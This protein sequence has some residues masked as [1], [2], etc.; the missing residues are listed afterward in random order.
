MTAQT[1]THGF[2]LIREQKLSEINS[3]ARYYRHVST[4]AELLSLLNSDEN[5]VF[6]V[7]FG[8]PP[9]DSTG[10]AHIL[11]HSVLCGSRKYPIK[12]PFVELM[13]SS[14]NTFLNAMTFPDKTCYPVASQNVQDF[15][16]LIDVYLDAVFHPRLT[17]HIFEQEGW[18]YELDT[19]EAPLTY[20]GVVFNEM[21]GNYSSPDS[22]LHELAQ[23]SLYPD[24]TYGLDSGGDPKHIP[25]LTYQQLKDF[26]QRHYHP[27]NAKL[28]FYGD[29]DPDERLRLLDGWLGEF[30]RIEVD[31]KVPLQPRF[32]AP[33][34]LQRTYAAGKA[35]EAPQEAPK[36]SMIS[37]NWMLDEIVDVET[38]LAFDILEHI[39][40]GTPAAPLY[41]ALIDSGL[42]EGLAGGG[43]DDGLRQPMFSIGLKGIDPANADKIE[44]LIIDTIGT[45]AEEGIDPL[46]VEAALNTVEFHL[47][48]NNTGSFPRGIVFMLRALRTWLH[49]RD[50]LSPLAFSGPLA[51]IKGRVAGGRYFEGLLRRHFIDNPHRTSL[52]LRPDSEQ[53]EREAAAERSR[54]DA[55]RSG[56]SANDLRAVVD[57]T[58][59]L[60]R[61]QEQADPPEALATIPTLTL[62]DLPRENKLTPIETTSLADTR[63]LYHDLFTN[64]VV[65]LDVGFDLHVLPAELLPYVQLFSR[66][67]L[68]TGV[69]NDDFVRLSQRIGRSTGGIRPQRWTSAVWGGNATAAWLNLRGKALPEQTGELLAILQDILARARLDN[70]ERFQQLV[71][72]EKA[73]MESRLVPA[74][75]S[76]VDHR[77]RAAFHESDWADEQMGGV[78]YL[79]FLRKLADEVETNWEGVLA[80]LERIRTMLVNRSIMLCNVTAAYGDWERLAPQ[81]ADFLRALPRTAAKAAPWRLADTPRSEGLVIP[82]QVNY[83]GKGADLYHEGLKPSGAH[84]VVR[85][86]LGTTWLWDKVRVQG[87]AYG[88]HCMF[89]RFSGGFTFVSYRDPNL[90]ATL[91]IYDRTAGFLK[92]AD[93][94]ADELTRNI[95]GTIGDVDTYRLPDAKGFASMQRHL[96]GDTDAV[97]QKM[98]EEILSTTAADIRNFADAMA[99]VAAK[100]RIVVLGSEQ[101]IEAANKERPGLLTV[102]KVM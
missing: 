5:K 10:V 87:G 35:D 18:H 21:K 55:V 58:A 22:M 29:D 95:I 36:E 8:T 47:R 81:L 13:K 17:R 3:T 70:R 38:A 23:Q 96:I 91:D 31:A 73:A 41:K 88:G 72:E 24:I 46:T 94:S 83:V 76:Y 42:G 20:K 52:T 62:A 45:L 11:E 90:L 61:L 64:G 4:G 27:S 2:E 60:K 14:L 82:T 79:F 19:P 40:I 1:A 28:F 69:G 32:A 7:S 99:E 67:L 65:Y 26:H 53:A 93:L 75:S 48:E 100:G 89:N 15:Y 6:G 66:A 85:R 49:G 9:S 33:K 25:D 30:D 102:S 78:S 50:P 71:L 34:R 86:Y 51:G 92:S 54:L 12:E 44:R 84:L 74:G 63:V 16:N 57:E 39:L 77:L 97:R 59:T 101:A 98:R 56:M 68:E 43:L 80:A 37:V